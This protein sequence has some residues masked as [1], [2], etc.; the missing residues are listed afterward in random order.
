MKL[1]ITNVEYNDDKTQLEIELSDGSKQSLSVE[2]GSV[3]FNN[4]TYYLINKQLQIDERIKTGDF[5]C[6]IF[7]IRV[8][9]L[10]DTF[11][12]EA[13]F[14]KATFTQNAN[15]S[16]ATFTQQAYFYETT[17]IQ[18]AN[19]SE[20]T[21]AQQANFS[22][23]TFTLL[24]DFSEATFTQQ[25]YFSEAIFTQQAYFSEATFTKEAYFWG[26]IFKK[27]ADFSLTIFSET[28][29]LNFIKAEVT[30]LNLRLSTLKRIEYGEAKF[31]A[32]NRETFLILKNIALKQND[33]IRALEFHKQEYETHF[34][35]L[36]WRK[37]FSDK[38][39]LGFEKFVSEFGTN[40]VLALVIFVLLVT[41]F[42]VLILAISGNY[43]NTTMAHFI[44][45]LS[46][47]NY[48][49]E[50]MFSSVNWFNG[51]LFIFYKVLQL[52]IIYEIIKSFRK[53]SRKL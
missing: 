33:H 11:T 53:F 20:A 24:A 28:S 5:F 31:S 9:F 23:A 48:D 14:S 46:P 47:I 15:F 40:V 16:E 8:N 21:F 32:D 30:K 34:K 10:E 19:F 35:K 37:N 4:E 1:I 6:C 27:E 38:F 13:D 18:D 3:Y 41:A 2:N 7:L 26:V 49:I 44:K 51:L 36:E 12:K 25:A 22:E 43:D 50:S 17:F 39:V 29:V 45:F 52:V 42:Y